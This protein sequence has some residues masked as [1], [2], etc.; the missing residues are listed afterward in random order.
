M[1]KNKLNDLMTIFKN[2]KEI[3]EEINKMLKY[4]GDLERFKY[5]ITLLNNIESGKK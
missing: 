1:R 3:K 4:G 2:E 5:L